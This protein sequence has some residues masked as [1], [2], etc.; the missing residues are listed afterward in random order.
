MA[1]DS[2]SEVY[3]YRGHLCVRF[4]YGLPAHNHPYDDLVDRLQSI[5]YPPLCYPSYGALAFAPVG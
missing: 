4:R 2:T 3:G 5:G 1:V